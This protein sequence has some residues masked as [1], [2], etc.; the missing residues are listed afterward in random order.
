M[1]GGLYWKFMYFVLHYEQKFHYMIVAIFSITTI[2][3]F[4]YIHQ[5]FILKYCTVALTS[6]T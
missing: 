6:A 3:H 5:F 1:I 4:N 2:D